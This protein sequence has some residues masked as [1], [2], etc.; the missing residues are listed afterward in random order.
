MTK[1]KFVARP[2]CTRCLRYSLPAKPPTRSNASVRCSIRPIWSSNKSKTSMTESQF[3]SDMKWCDWKNTSLTTGSN[4][5]LRK[6]FP[7]THSSPLTN[8]TVGSWGS[9]V[10]KQG[11]LNTKSVLGLN[12]QDVMDRF[13][14]LTVILNSGIVMFICF[15]KGMHYTICNQM[16]MFETIHILKC[17]SEASSRWTGWS[18]KRAYHEG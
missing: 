14:N 12:Q 10:L 8:P 6:R 1:E 16:G 4:T 3:L 15:T 2:T 9:S 5:S 13:V 7:G 11:K 17:A 18:A